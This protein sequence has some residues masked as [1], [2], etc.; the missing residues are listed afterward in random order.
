[1]KLCADNKLHFKYSSDDLPEI[2]PVDLSVFTKDT[3]I[4]SIEVCD[5]KLRMHYN[6]SKL[7]YLE[8]DLSKYDN[9]IN[10]VRQDT[11]HD[12]ITFQWSTGDLSTVYLSK[13]ANNDLSGM[14]IHG[15]SLLVLKFKDGSSK[16]VQLSAFDKHIE[17]YLADDNNL[18]L[19]FNNGQGCVVIDKNDIGKNIT[20]ARVEDRVLWL[21]YSDGSEPISA[22]LPELPNMYV[23]SGKLEDG[24]L[25]LGYEDGSKNVSVDVSDLNDEY[26]DSIILGYDKNL[27]FKYKVDSTKD[28]TVDLSAF[29]NELIGHTF[30]GNVLSCGFANGK[31]ALIDLCKFDKFT[32]DISLSSNK[33]TLT[34]N[35]GSKLTVDLSEL[36]KHVNGYEVVDGVLKFKYKNSDD[37]LEAQLSDINFELTAGIVSDN[38]DNMQLSFSNGKSPVSIDTTKLNIHV[39]SAEIVGSK[40]KLNMTNHDAVEVDLAQFANELTNVEYTNNNVILNFANGK[41][42]TLDLGKFNMFINNAYLGDSTNENKFVLTYN[43]P[44]R[45]HLEVNLDKFDK[46]VSTASVADGSLVAT[47]NNNKGQAFSIPLAALNYELTSGEVGEDN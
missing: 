24:K 21:D 22:A 4:D 28:T 44:E 23:L 3:Y 5:N 36:D 30:V 18:S 1:M 40:L 13:Y 45:A 42:T 29:D 26:I 11:E 43:N 46:Y 41:H 10:A 27:H 6:D 20:A 25:V 12:N 7:P 14:Y 15:D 37:V 34:D 32:Q 19:A 33:L 38:A 17:S 31:N 8:A 16:S 47:Y 9:H 39:S 2:E 35:T